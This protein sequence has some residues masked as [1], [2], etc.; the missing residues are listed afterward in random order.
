MLGVAFYIYVVR[1]SSIQNQSDE[2]KSL[3][4]KIIKKSG[5]SK[6]FVFHIIGII[7]IL[8]VLDFFLYLLLFYV[9][10][11]LLMLLFVVMTVT[12]YVLGTNQ[13]KQQTKQQQTGRRRWENI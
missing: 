10:F 1:V 5:F 11:Y 9:Y 4:S 2:T 13:I 12:G 6:L 8:M 7:M 3:S